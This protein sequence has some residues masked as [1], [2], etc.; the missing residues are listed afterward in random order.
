MTAFSGNREVIRGFPLLP[1]EGH[2]SEALSETVACQP[3]PRAVAF[4]H[5]CLCFVTDEGHVVSSLWGGVGELWRRVCGYSVFFLFLGWLQGGD[6][7]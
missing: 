6:Q 2:L 3:L 1:G 7:G 4:R 5:C